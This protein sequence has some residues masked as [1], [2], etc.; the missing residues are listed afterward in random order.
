MKTFYN[1]MTFAEKK[2][3]RAVQQARNHGLFTFGA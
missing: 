2:K 1:E 3:I